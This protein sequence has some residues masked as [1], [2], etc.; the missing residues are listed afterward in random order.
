MQRWCGHRDAASK[1]V[2]AGAE[3]VHNPAE[4]ASGWRPSLPPILLT[5][6]GSV[7]F[8]QVPR[9]RVVSMGVG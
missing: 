9:F 7:I 3:A 5:I 2:P 4:L 1:P 6:R 8:S